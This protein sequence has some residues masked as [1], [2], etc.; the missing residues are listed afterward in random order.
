MIRLFAGDVLVRAFDEQPGARAVLGQHGLEVAMEDEGAIERT[1]QLPGEGDRPLEPVAK[2]LQR[3]PEIVPHD[4]GAAGRA[5]VVARVRVAGRCLEQHLE[6][7]QEIVL[8]L[9]RERREPRLALEA[10][11]EV[12][13][14]RAAEQAGVRV[15]HTARRGLGPV[16][17][18]RAQ[19]VAPRRHGVKLYG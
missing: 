11:L 2:D 10:L 16:P 14:P 12:Q 4:G 3:G 6:L 1:E 8:V 9:E 15:V 18:L 17:W 7:E 19:G 13:P 5:G